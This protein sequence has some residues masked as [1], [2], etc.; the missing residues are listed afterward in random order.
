[1]AFLPTFVQTGAGAYVVFAITLSSVNG[2]YD[3]R[4][5]GDAGKWNAD[6]SARLPECKP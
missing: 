4:Y 5:N 1:M 2:V 6:G 3:V